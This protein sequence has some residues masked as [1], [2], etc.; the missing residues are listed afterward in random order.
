M[1]KQCPFAGPLPSHASEQGE[2]R[3][4]TLWTSIIFPYAGPQHSSTQALLTFVAREVL[5]LC[6]CE[7]VYFD[8]DCDTCET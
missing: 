3:F 8:P 7:P 1:A 4:V 2:P 5:E 6:W